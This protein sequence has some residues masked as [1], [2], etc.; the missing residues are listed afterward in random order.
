MSETLSFKQRFNLLQ[1][2]LKAPKSQTNKFGGYQYRSLEDIT[3]AVKPLLKSY[4][5]LL[6]I[7]DQ[8]VLVGERYYV[9]ATAIISDVH[10][11][12]YTSSTAMAREEENKKGMD[13]SQLTGSTSSYARK[14]ALNGLF[15]IDD[16]KDSD[17]TNK[18]GKDVKEEE[19]KP[20][21]VKVSDET[22]IKLTS[23]LAEGDDE[24]IIKLFSN[25]FYPVK[26]LA[27]ITEEYAQ[28]LI[29]AKTKV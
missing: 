24:K 12:E 26:I 28:R 4:E 1:T 27:E 19:D 25:K 3:E 21:P 23:L 5:L 2:E 20:E 11:D 9:M 8:I 14:Y 29:K 13:S 7:S 17:A 16:T 18:H 15:A 6:N 22:L 10:S